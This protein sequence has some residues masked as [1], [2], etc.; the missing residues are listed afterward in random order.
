MSCGR[1]SRSWT[2]EPSSST[3]EAAGIAGLRA[4]ALFEAGK[5]FL[6]L[7]AGT[8]LLLYVHRD[9]QPFAEHLLTHLHLN[10]ASRYPRIFMRLAEAATPGRIRLLA[11][12]ALVYSA[13]RLT[14]AWGLWRARAWAEWLGVA[15]AFIY[16]PFELRA[17]IARPGIE[18]VGALLTNL[19]VI[20]FLGWQLRRRRLKRGS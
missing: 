1:R 16:L 19:A 3:A 10:P 8:G 13:A 7:A 12:G 9:I 15:T 4:I 14:E 20:T 5:G 18:P 2:T 17:S 11:L 6:V